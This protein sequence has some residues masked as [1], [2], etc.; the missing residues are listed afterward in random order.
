M[1]LVGLQKLQIRFLAKCKLQ[2]HV[3][4]VKEQVKCY[5][6]EAQVLTRECVNAVAPLG[7]KMM[8]W[9]GGGE[10]QGGGV[11]PRP[12]GTGVRAPV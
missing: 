10:G 6:T 12:P 4:T 5:K 11:H 3:P 7:R 2:A 1:E 8:G 9:E